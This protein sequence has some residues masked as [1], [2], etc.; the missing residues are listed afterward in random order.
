MKVSIHKPPISREISRTNQRHNPTGGWTEG[1]TSLNII[2]MIFDTHCHGYWRSLEHRRS[3]MRDNM[4]AARVMRTMQVAVDLES[5]RMSLA[6]AREWGEET[7]CTAGFHPTACQ[8][9]S[10][11]SVDRWVEQLEDFIG[12]NRDKVAGVGETGLDYYHLTRGKEETQKRM[13]RMS[14]G[15]QA[16]LAQRVGL[17][18]IIHTR[19]AAADTLALIR[20]FG[21]RQAVIHC[22]SENV[23]FAQDLLAWSDQIHFSFSGILTY[24]KSLAVQDAARTLRLDRILVET[25]SPFLVPQAVRETFSVNE[26][27]FTRHVMEFLKTLRQEP[28]D[29]VEQTVWENSNRF[30]GIRK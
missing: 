11:H 19:N 12:I 7:W 25:D 24:K 28:G 30:F 17:P 3:E 29:V 1:A 10:P 13:Q 27:A 2:A 22:F 21:I 18:L 4:R 20:E 15:V 14:F 8:D 16:E 26:P 5:C 9:M 6:L 23:S